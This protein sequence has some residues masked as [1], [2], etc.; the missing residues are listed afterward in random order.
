MDKKIFAVSKESALL[1]LTYECNNRCRFCY[2]RLSDDFWHL[3]EKRAYEFIDDAAS[4]GVRQIEFLGGE[5]TILPY[6][7]RAVEY[8]KKSF[9]VITIL[10]NGRMFHDLDFARAAVDSGLNDVGI[11]FHGSTR[12]LHD[13]LSQR[14]GAFEQTTQG[15]RNLVAL[16]KEG[17]NIYLWV[18]TT[19]SE[20]NMQDLV[21]LG[22]LLRRLG[23]VSWR[24][25]CLQAMGSP[26]YSDSLPSLRQTIEEHA[27]YIYIEVEGIPLCLYGEML[28]YSDSENPYDSPDIGM[29]AE[30]IEIKQNA[31]S[32]IAHLPGCTR[33]MAFKECCMTDEGY[34]KRYGTKEFKAFSDGAFR[35]ALAQ[36]REWRATVEGGQ[37]EHPKQEWVR[38]LNS[39][40][41]VDY[42]VNNNHCDGTANRPSYKAF[43]ALEEASLSGDWRRVRREATRILAD[44]PDETEATRMKRIAE[45]QLINEETQSLIKRKEFKRA[46]KLKAIIHKLYRDVLVSKE[47]K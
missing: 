45:V 42:V 41:I 33:C 4:Q 15:L 7:L 39:D 26:Y 16:Q 17:H 1:V 37:R 5:V 20:S 2:T 44:F 31:D 22:G 36:G 43:R 14:Q 47:D 23:I 3:P 21:A 32:Q 27:R 18:S 13:G 30:S 40:S 10:S 8:A 11:S 29:S 24:L 9:D 6:F 46:R 28:G 34:T 38:L 12:E 35:Q 25:K 19:F